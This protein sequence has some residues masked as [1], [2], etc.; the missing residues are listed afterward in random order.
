MYPIVRPDHQPFLALAKTTLTSFQISSPFI[1]MSLYIFSFH[2]ISSFDSNNDSD[3][4]ISKT[5]T[6]DKDGIKKLEMVKLFE[7]RI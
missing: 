3:I 5:N 6:G 4:S 7:A 1:K 2:I